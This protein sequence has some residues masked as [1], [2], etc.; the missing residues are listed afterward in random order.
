MDPH[1]TLNPGADNSSST[2]DNSTSFIEIVGDAVTT[3]CTAVD[4]T[5]VFTSMDIGNSEFWGSAS[6]VWRAFF[7]VYCVFFYAPLL[8]LFCICFYFLCVTG[9]QAFSYRTPIY[10]LTLYIFWCTFSSAY[11][12]MIINSIANGSS[13]KA[14]A[15]V[16]RVLET[17]SSSSFANIMIVAFFSYRD[18][19]PNSRNLIPLKQ[20]FFPTMIIYLE[21]FIIVMLSFISGHRLVTLI[22]ALLIASRSLMLITIILMLVIGIYSKYSVRT[23]EQCC[24]LWKNSKSLVVII[25][26]FL[27]SYVY[28]LYPLG[29]VVESNNCI[30]N[31]QLNRAV[32]LVLSFLLRLCEVS[33]SIAYFMKASNF[34]KEILNESKL[35]KDLSS[36]HEV[37]E[38][39]RSVTFQ[40]SYDPP[41]KARPI[42]DPYDSYLEEAAQAHDEDYH[43]IKK[44]S[45]TVKASPSSSTITDRLQDISEGGD[46]DAVNFSDKDTSSIILNG[47]AM[48]YII[49]NMYDYVA[50]YIVYGVDIVIAK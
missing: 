27:L 25:P 16:T 21:A 19:D 18:P 47:E 44:I 40:F 45:S 41:P 10:L 39:R 34:A 32:W 6:T 49:Y 24:L 14:V 33:F 13:S 9:K 8:G 15:I 26:Y 3:S 46:S 38:M 12:I 11:G 50:T 7:I 31:V 20:V 48:F 43:P 5:E 17:A 29:T 2:A 36:S 30:D 22:F 4:V 35:K 37:I 42:G 1:I 28:F 23:K